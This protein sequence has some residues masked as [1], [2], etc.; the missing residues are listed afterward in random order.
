MRACL[1]NRAALHPLCAV[2]TLQFYSVSP[3]LEEHPEY[4]DAEGTAPLFGTNMAYLIH[5]EDGA[6]FYFVKGAFNEIKF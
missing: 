2:V 5:G 4:A 6:K 1:T 3:Y